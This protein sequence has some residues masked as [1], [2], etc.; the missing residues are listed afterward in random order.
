ML[1]LRYLRFIQIVLWSLLA[2]GIL[3]SCMWSVPITSRRRCIFIPSELEDLFVEA[4]LAGFTILVG[5]FGGFRFLSPAHPTT[6]RVSGVLE[7]LKTGLKKL[8]VDSNHFD[9]V[10]MVVDSSVREYY[11]HHLGSHILIFPKYVH[12]LRFDGGFR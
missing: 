9:I 5:G 2:L 7:R 3:L 4:E 1:G 10:V 6:M 11:S 12:G 8:E